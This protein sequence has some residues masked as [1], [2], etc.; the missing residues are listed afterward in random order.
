MSSS[1]AHWAGTGR[2]LLR[3]GTV[4][5]QA[6]PFAT[7]MLVHGHEIAWV[8]SE[9]AALAMTDG[10]DD[11]V[12]LDGAL[13]TPAFVDAQAE[14][15]V[16]DAAAVAAL[17]DGAARLGVGALQGLCR[18]PLA[19]EGFAGFAGALSQPGP[20]LRAYVP[21]GGPTALGDVWDA[22]AMGAAD[23][24]DMLRRAAAAAAPGA[25]VATDEAALQ[26]AMAALRTAAAELGPA[27]LGGAGIRL[28]GGAGCT[29]QDAAALAALGVPVVLVPDPDAGL[30]TVP[31]ATMAAEGVALALGSGPGGGGPWETVRAAV[32]HPDP[33]QRI[34]A[35]A[36][37]AAHTRGGWRAAG[38]AAQGV[39]V[40][41][42]PAHYAVWEVDELLVQAP[43]DRIQAWSTDPRSGTPGL[44]DL[45]EQA[46]PPRCLRTVVWGRTVAAVP[47]S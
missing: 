8:G 31:V 37:F 38:A 1:P 42:A 7:A 30:A 47:P 22:G 39:L 44:P 28:H 17:R 36:A 19:G 16:W 21:G 18:T 5:S 20:L 35:R 23:L 2:V 3:G 6:D 25:L 10:V 12:D 43:D 45:R 14:P 9:G 29:Q 15:P 32:H 33:L 26:R 40:P 13:V 24:L 41:G 4:Y 11:V 46:A 34:S 27:V